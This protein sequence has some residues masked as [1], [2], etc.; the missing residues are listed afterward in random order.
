MEHKLSQLKQLKQITLSDEE[1]AY[2]RGRL[3]QAV[4]APGPVTEPLFARGMQHGLRIALSSFLFV[5]FVGGSMSAIASNAL[6]GDPLYAFKINVNEEIKAALL[7]TPEEKVAYTQ[8]RIS[9]RVNEIKTL[10]QTKT[11]TK[12]KQATAQKAL[13]EN[14]QDLSTQLSTISDTSTALSVT[15]NLE[16][17]LKDD[18][19]AIQSTLAANADDQAAAATLKAIDGTLKKVSDQEVQ[20]LSKEIDNI[21][22]EI[23]ATNTDTLDVDANGEVKGEVTGP[24]DDEETDTEKEDPES[25]SEPS[26]TPVSP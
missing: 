21:A 10:A 9:N 17:N 16:Q 19:A 5:I 1:R 24:T 15:A 2:L 12:A 20:I 18:K 26:T 14:I 11:L 4:M 23:D 7:S 6:P 25:E 22:D 3:A 8:N 13:D